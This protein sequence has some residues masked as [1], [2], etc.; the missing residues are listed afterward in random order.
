ML[1]G[2]NLSLAKGLLVHWSARI[3]RERGQMVVIGF[4]G[5]GAQ[6]LQSPTR[7]GPRNEQWI[8]P[9]AGGGGTPV[10]AGLQLAEEL[11]ARAR[12]G[13]RPFAVA[14]WLLSDGRFEPLPPRPT[15][16]DTVGLVDFES[17]RVRLGRMPRLA[18]A[19][20]APCWSIAQLIGR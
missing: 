12:K 15:F 8:R 16:A 18:D 1:K 10:T 7:A 6:V 20:D 4:S 14:L 3:Y 13:R 9:I 17:T 5:N 2:R 11:V 19:W